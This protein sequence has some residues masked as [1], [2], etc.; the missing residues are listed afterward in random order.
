MLGSVSMV[1]TLQQNGKSRTLAF[2][3]DVGRKNL[4]IIKDPETMPEVDYLIMESTYGDR[5]HS[6]IGK[7]EDKLA[8]TIIRTAARGGRIIAPSFAVGRTQQLVLVLHELMK[9]GRIPDIPVFVDSPLAVDATEAFRE[10]PECYDEETMA[11]VEAG[12]D[13]FQFARLRYVRDVGESKALN[14]LRGPMI[15]ISASGMCETGRILH[16]LRNNIENPRNTV[17]ITGFQ[18][19]HTLGRKIVEKQMEVPI[20][21]EP[22]RLRAEVVKL[23]EL[24]GHADQNELLQWMKPMVSRLKRVFLVH[25][26]P[27]QQL[28]L[29]KAIEGIYG[30]PVTVPGRGEGYEL[31]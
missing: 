4:P 13:P 11:F 20:F 5:L 30:L 2:S 23:N 19:E 16:H 28:A 22:V 27:S 9:K 12:Q 15:I 18:A 26:E 14:E 3:G 25:G 6:E 10:N 31:E 8:E 7:V 21:G 1:L 29:Q 24:S 17:L